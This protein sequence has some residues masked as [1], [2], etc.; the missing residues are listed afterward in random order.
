MTTPVIKIELPPETLRAIE[1]LKNLR[2][3]LQ[4]AVEDGMNVGAALTVSDIQAQRLTGQGPY[5][6]QDGKLGI[7]TGRLRSSLR[8]TPA[9]SDDSGT[10]VTIGTNVKYAAIHEFGG[11]I[12]RTVKPGIARLRTNKDGSLLKRGNLATFA[13]LKHKQVREVAYAGGKSYAIKIPARMPIGHGVADN[14]VTFTREISAAIQRVF[15]EQ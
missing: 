12:N 4:K 7:K 1:R 3:S 14:E 9:V 15:E 2:A 11:T 5:P 10:M 13:R 6:V 8:H